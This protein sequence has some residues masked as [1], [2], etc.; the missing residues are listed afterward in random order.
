MLENTEG[1]SKNEQSRETGNIGYTRR[2]KTN[3]KR[4]MCWTPLYANKHKKVHLQRSNLMVP[5]I[6]VFLFSRHNTLV[7]CIGG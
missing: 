2:G 5:N 4:N 1:A 3:Q 7:H 6:R